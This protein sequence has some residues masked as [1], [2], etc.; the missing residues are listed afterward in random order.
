[1]SAES[2]GQEN[3]LLRGTVLKNTHEIVGLVVYTGHETKVMMNQGGF[4]QK[5]SSVDTRINNIQMVLAIVLVLMSVMCGLL[6]T[7]VA[8]S[9]T[10][11]YLHKASQ[12]SVALEGISVFTKVPPPDSLAFC[13]STS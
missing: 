7:G 12:L 10:T 11:F 6:Y 5:T 8:V 3:L 1:M 4:K 13:F 2:L 9:G